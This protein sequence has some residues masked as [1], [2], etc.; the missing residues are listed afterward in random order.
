MY[1]KPQKRRRALK[2]SFDHKIFDS[3]HKVLGTIRHTSPLL[4]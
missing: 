1:G 3:N 4:P 2:F